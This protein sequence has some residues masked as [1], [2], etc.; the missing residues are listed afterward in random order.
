MASP[1]FIELL[2]QL[3]ET[4]EQKLLRWEPVKRSHYSSR[5]DFYL[6]LGNGVVHVT[7]ND[8]DE[9]TW[10][11]NYKVSL[12]TRDG[13]LVDELETSQIEASYS[14]LIRDLY[15]QARSA[16]FNLPR[17]V[18]EMQSD[19]VAGRTRELPKDLLKSDEDEGIPF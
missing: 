18:E 3:H 15:R 7:S 10:V 11:A 5:C 12:L 14:Q 16:A 1:Q 19:L 9:E 4:G 17:L 2:K 8:D 13:L 6:A